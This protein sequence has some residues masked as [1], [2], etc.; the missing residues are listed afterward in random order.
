MGKRIYFDANAGIPLLAEV[1]EAVVAALHPGTVETKFTAAYEPSHG[2]LR[3]EDAAQRL[4]GALDR[5]EPGDTGRFWD[6]EGREVP[7]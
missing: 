7:W 2:K 1:R 6:H 3:P 4:L 5:L